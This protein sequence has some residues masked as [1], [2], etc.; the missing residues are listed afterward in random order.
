MGSFCNHKAFTYKRSTVATQ[1]LDP[2]NRRISQHGWFQICPQ[3]R[4]IVVHQLHSPSNR[5][6]AV[7]PKGGSQFPNL[8]PPP[9]PPPTFH[10]WANL[11]TV[12]P[13]H[14]LYKLPL[15]LTCPGQLSIIDEWVALLG[16]ETAARGEA[17]ERTCLR[18]RW[19]LEEADRAVITIT[20]WLHLHDTVGGTE[21][22]AERRWQLHL[23]SCLLKN[24][25][26]RN[27]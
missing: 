18:V 7:C 14:T 25:A 12:H 21:G 1:N 11:L 15:H 20:N 4:L 2:A 17:E 19:G 23:S 8:S 16:S 10:L 3:G 13:H 26:F 6:L 27:N 22:N 5:L 24:E 9:H